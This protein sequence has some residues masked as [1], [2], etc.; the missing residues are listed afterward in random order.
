MPN[1]GTARFLSPKA[2]SFKWENRRLKGKN[3]SKMTDMNN[4]PPEMSSCAPLDKERQPT[5]AL[6]QRMLKQAPRRSL[7][8]RIIVNDGAYS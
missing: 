1:L 5:A 8:M 2:P 7:L 3:L 6:V 4:G